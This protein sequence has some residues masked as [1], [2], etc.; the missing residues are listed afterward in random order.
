M[1]KYESVYNAYVILERDMSEI[2]HDIKS[3]NYGIAEEK[4]SAACT[5]LKLYNKTLLKLIDDDPKS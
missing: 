4:L 5:A 2:I 1:E 3:C